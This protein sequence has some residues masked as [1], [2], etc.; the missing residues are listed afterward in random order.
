LP[1]GTTTFSVPLYEVMKI[2][3]DI[4]DDIIMVTKDTT[5][6]SITL[7]AGLKKTD[8]SSV[9]AKVECAS[10]TGRDLQTRAVALSETWGVK[11]IMPTYQSDGTCNADAKV[12][13]IRP[14]SVTGDNVTGLLTI[15]LSMK[16]GATVVAS[17]SIQRVLEVI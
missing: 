2:A 17:R 15:T 3:E 11:L 12:M 14:T 13:V 5:T 6:L 4:T 10:G 7:P 8:F 1:N 9:L 16:G